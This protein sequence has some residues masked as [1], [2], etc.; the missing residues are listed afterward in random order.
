MRE[1]KTGLMTNRVVDEKQKD[2]VKHS[3]RTCKRRSLRS[4]EVK[5]TQLQSQI[6]ESLKK[7]SH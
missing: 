2:K 4:K 3:S 5:V 6:T 1:K 7:H